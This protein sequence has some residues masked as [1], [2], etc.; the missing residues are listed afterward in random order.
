MDQIKVGVIGVG[1]MGSN[2]ARV[3]S[4]LEDS[5]LVA[6]CDVSE[7]KARAI[8]EKYRCE[9]YVDAEQF[10]S[11]SGVNAVVIATPTVTHKDLALLALEYGKHILIEKPLAA[12]VEEAKAICSKASSKNAVL[13]VGFIE[14]FNPA[15]TEAKRLLK[16]GKIG[17]PILLEARRLSEWPKR[18][19]DVGVVVDLAI[20][21]IDIARY[22]FEKDPVEV[23][24]C[25][26]SLRHSFE[27]YAN[28]LLRYENGETAFIE[29][30]WLTPHKVRKLTIT[31]SDG[32]ISLDYI[33][34]EIEIENN[35][36][37]VRPRLANQEPLKLE[38]SHFLSCVKSA[39]QPLVT[40][41]DGVKALKIAE[42][43]LESSK[44]H[45]IMKLDL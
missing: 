7:E 15:V 28:I 40:G 3:L 11:N 22:V 42:L 39:D 23:Y 38:L 31:G 1:A 29:T 26:G 36:E 2:H 14:R 41:E 43:A 20:H 6:V 44:V 27:D 21:D 35:S 13:T 8:A 24:G 5:Q 37:L 18:I 34:Q 12:T 10:L 4:E 16:S 25:V 45:R 30:N 9:Y 17:H 33:S 19:G 32:L